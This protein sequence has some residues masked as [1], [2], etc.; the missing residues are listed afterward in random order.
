MERIVNVDAEYKTM[1][2]QKN[3]ERFA[4]K[5]PAAAAFCE[6]DSYK[7]ED[8]RAALPLTDKFLADGTVN[9]DWTYYFDIDFDC[10]TGMYVWYIER[11]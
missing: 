4:Q 5:F 6:F 10:G 2:V 3:L 7:I 8:I 9:N 1:N 11:A